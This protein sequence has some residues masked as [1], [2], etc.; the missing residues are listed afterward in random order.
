MRHTRY[1]PALFLASQLAIPLSQSYVDFFNDGS[2][3]V[4]SIE[5]A[6]P[7]GNDWKRVKL[8]GVTGGGWVSWK[9]GYTGHAMASI[10]TDRGCFYDVRIEFAEQKALLVKGFDA[11]HIHAMHINDLWQKAN[12]IS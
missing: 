10:D 1:V 5:L 11:C 8:R 2:D 7:D 6:T 9:G 12:R 4:V 3:S